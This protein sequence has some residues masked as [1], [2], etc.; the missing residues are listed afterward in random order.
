MLTC[1][2]PHC[3]ESIENDGS[4]AG[5]L[6]DCPTCGGGFEMPIPKAGGDPFQVTDSPRRSYSSG[7]NYGPQK[8]PGVAAVLSFFFLG[9]GQIYNGQ[10]GK[11]LLSWVA[12]FICAILALAFGIGVVLAFILWVGGIFDAYSSAERLNRRRR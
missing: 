3:N 4:L 9:L 7:R 1:S 8:S 2:C 10:I 5:Q 12:L 11:A 6:C